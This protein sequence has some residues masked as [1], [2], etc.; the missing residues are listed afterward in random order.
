[1][2][3]KLLRPNP[4]RFVILDII[5]GIAVFGIII[6]NFDVLSGYY[7]LSSEVKSSF[8]N[9]R[10]DNLIQFAQFL[11]VDGKFYSIFSILFGLG[12]TIFYHNVANKGINPRA[13]FYRRLWFLFGIGFIHFMFIWQGDILLL[14]AILGFAL[15]MFYSLSNRA[16]LI[17]AVCL[18]LSPIVLDLILL[19]LA[20]FPGPVIEAW[21]L[22]FAESAGN[23]DGYDFA[24]ARYTESLSFAEIMLWQFGGAIY[25]LIMYI[26]THRFPKVMGL[27]IIGLWIGRNEYYKNLQPHL[28]TLKKAAFWFWLIGFPCSFFMVIYHFDGKYI[29]Q[30]QPEGMMDTLFYTLSVVPLALCYLALICIWWTNSGGARLLLAFAPVGK[31]ALSNYIMQS[32]F[33]IFIFY[34]EWMGMGLKF[35][36]S[37][38]IP[39][40]LGLCI[41]QM[42]FSHWWLKRYEFGPLEKIWKWWTYKN[43]AKAY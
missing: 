23:T 42:I 40:A 6:M 38:Y 7:F 27:F 39:L 30:L 25:K 8:P 12:F 20:W 15:P 37:L 43:A 34:G 11:F 3:D 4:N 19:Q 1:M 13:I 18:I 28:G 33:G 2:D 9:A 16:L 17:W 5:R 14:Y 31:M 10:L 36:P 21:V 41:V 32:F 29:S 26:D 24:L 22:S 35:G